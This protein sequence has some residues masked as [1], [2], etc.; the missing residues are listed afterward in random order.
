LHGVPEKYR[1]VVQF[2]LATGARASEVAGLRWQDV[3]LTSAAVVAAGEARLP[4][5]IHFR[6]AWKYGKYAPLKTAK[7]RRDVPMTSG[8]WVELQT[9]YE[10][11]KPDSDVVFSVVRGKQPPKPIDM[12]NFL[13]KI[14]KPLGKTLGIPWLN[15]HC[16]RHTMSTWLD[17]AGTPM[18]QKN[19]LLGHANSKVGMQYTHAE[20]NTQREA[21]EDGIDKLMVS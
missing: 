9:L 20:S 21:L 15:V 3:N 19:L 12:H 6:H 13:N 17:A 18:G 1:P 11:R 7:A 10:R 16:L 14:I 4:H 8:V 2:I 5:M